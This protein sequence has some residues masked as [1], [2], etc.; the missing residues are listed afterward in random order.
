[1]VLQKGLKSTSWKDVEKQ[2]AAIDR[3]I[4][5]EMMK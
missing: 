3:E 2:R 1:M 4:E 5:K